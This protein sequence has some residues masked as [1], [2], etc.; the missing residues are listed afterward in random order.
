MIQ[1]L[2]AGQSTE[3]IVK[4]AV[5]IPHTLTQNSDK[6][7]VAIDKLPLILELVAE[8]QTISNLFAIPIQVSLPK[9]ELVK[10]EL[11]DNK[12]TISI[13]NTGQL[14]IANVRIS[15][16]QQYDIQS[17]EDEIPAGGSLHRVF[18]VPKDF[19]SKHGGI[20]NLQIKTSDLPFLVWNFKSRP[21]AKKSL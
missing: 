15:L 3:L 19:L 9:L 14:P 1:R 7:A 13:Q 12:F 10:T 16:N 11:I 4:L 20:I 17:D 6:S 18:F 8:E 5:K 2:E 21:I